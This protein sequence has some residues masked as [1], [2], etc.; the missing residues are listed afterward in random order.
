VRGARSARGRGR[1]ATGVAEARDGGGRD[2]RARGD[3][4]AGVFGGVGLGG[5]S[6]K[7]GKGK[8]R[9]EGEG[10]VD[11]VG[12]SS[13]PAGKGEVG[14]KKGSASGKRKGKEKATTA[15]VVV[16]DIEAEGTADARV[17]TRVVTVDEDIESEPE[18]RRDIEQ[19]WLSSDSSQDSDEDIVDAKRRPKPTRSGGGGLRPVR[20]PRVVPKDEDDIPT[21]KK[22]RPTKTIDLDE[23]DED[24]VEFV[25]EAPS[26][27]EK[28]KRSPVKKQHSKGKDGRGME[29]VAE[30]AERLRVDEDRSRLRSIFVDSR[31]ETKSSLKGKGKDKGKGKEREDEDEDEGRMFLMQ[32]PPITPFLIDP[33]ASASAS[34]QIN[35]DIETQQATQEKPSNIKSEQTEVPAPTVLTPHT[36]SMLPSGCVG[37][38][39]VHASG[40]ISLDWGGV[41]MEVRLGSQVGFLEDAVLVSANALEGSGQGAGGDEDGVSGE[42][43]EGKEGEGT[44]YAL[45]QVEGKLVV[46]PDWG[47]LYD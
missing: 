47:R 44:V 45:G 5:T 35:P 28:S 8:G 29:T 23:M 46:V 15:V 40:R 37:K 41:D 32:F 31:T 25:R 3:V 2:G 9:G 7:V 38:L 11:L 1:G 36:T 43:E 26:S 10:V 19:I 22:S 12:G 20:A 24:E 33:N 16:D 30:R 4:D 18:E 14:G 13:T 42:V 39:N 17:P 21:K 27:P 34:A 6:S